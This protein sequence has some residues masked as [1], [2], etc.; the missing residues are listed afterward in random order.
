MIQHQAESGF[1]DST[2]RPATLPHAKG[3]GVGS[4]QLALSERKLKPT[5][6]EYSA[7]NRG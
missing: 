5:G 4:R 2:C 7:L 1:M 6:C 3:R